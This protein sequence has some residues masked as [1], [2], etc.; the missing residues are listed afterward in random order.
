MHFEAKGRIAWTKLPENKVGLTFVDLTEASRSQ[1]KKWL[2]VLVAPSQNPDAAE[3][4][5]PSRPFDRHV[6]LE[7]LAAKNSDA[8]DKVSVSQAR[9]ENATFKK[10]PRGSLQ[11]K[12]WEEKKL[13]TAE[14]QQNFLIQ[15]WAKD[16][17]RSQPAVRPLE[18]MEKP[19]ALPPIDVTERKSV[20]AEVGPAIAFRFAAPI[21]GIESERREFLT[22][23]PQ[24]TLRPE[25]H[26]NSMLPSIPNRSR[27]LETDKSLPGKS[28]SAELR[29]N[30]TIQNRT[31]DGVPIQS[32]SPQLREIAEPAALRAV[33]SPET[34]TIEARVTESQTERANILRWRY[35]PNLTKYN[36]N[37]RMLKRL[38]TRRTPA[39][40][41][42][43]QRD[44]EPVKFSCFFSINRAAKLSKE[45]SVANISNHSEVNTSTTQAAAAPTLFKMNGRKFHAV[46]CS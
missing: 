42:Q 36:L 35:S 1:I 16:D 32:P 24:E 39:R 14:L 6:K 12:S 7:N 25:L 18:K 10:P 11:P 17:S 33:W 19:A 3:L 4:V 38:L 41:A 27:A 15:A 40:A 31:K 23:A 29:K 44:G 28:E 5:D 8:R 26:R 2:S 37:F 21:P 13:A 9:T 43:P 30:I 34:K 22:N 46:M 45:T 20:E